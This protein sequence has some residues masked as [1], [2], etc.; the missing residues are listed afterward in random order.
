MTNCTEE[1]AKSALGIDSIKQKVKFLFFVKNFVE[2]YAKAQFN[3]D[4]N[5][6]ALSILTSQMK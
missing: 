5:A 1:R 3:N 2:S 4:P 6:A